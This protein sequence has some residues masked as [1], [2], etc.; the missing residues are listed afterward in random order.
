MCSYL[1]KPDVYF[2]YVYKSRQ[3]TLLLLHRFILFAY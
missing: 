2:V 3:V 1:Y